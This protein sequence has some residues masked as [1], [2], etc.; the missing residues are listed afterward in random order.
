VARLIESGRER[1]RGR[2]EDRAI[3]SKVENERVG[4]MENGPQPHLGLRDHLNI[5]G[6]KRE[7]G[8]KR[9]KWRKREREEGRGNQGGREPE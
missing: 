5:I 8:R 4:M 6:R 3:V 2:E 9:A 7:S 1:G